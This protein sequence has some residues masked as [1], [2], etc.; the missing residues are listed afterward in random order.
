MI[1]RPNIPSMPPSRPT[2]PS[3]NIVRGSE[4]S[5]RQRIMQKPNAIHSTGPI[6]DNSQFNITYGNNN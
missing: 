4:L 2:P 5:P 6:D 3:K 1:S